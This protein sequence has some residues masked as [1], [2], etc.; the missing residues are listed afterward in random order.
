MPHIQVKLLEGK[1]EAQKQKL[2]EE[3]VKAA[4]QAI[5]F[6]DESY[7]VSIEEFT[8]GEWK[9]DIYPKEIMGRKEILYKEPGYSM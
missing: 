9:K 2:A 8:M 4:Q 5:G 1:T 6:G 3:L 7:S